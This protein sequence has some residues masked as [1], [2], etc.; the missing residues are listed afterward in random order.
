M[1]FEFMMLLPHQKLTT[2][3]L[4]NLADMEWGKTKPTSFKFKEVVFE[5]KSWRMVYVG[6]IKILVDYKVLISSNLPIPDYFGNSRYF[7]NKKP[8][9]RSKRN[10]TDPEK[11]NDMYFECHYN[12]YTKM[13]N[14]I[15]AIEMSKNISLNEFEVEFLS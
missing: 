14:L 7:A 10:F 1:Q 4:Q 6:I 9:H 5:V 8:I 3:N 11:I 12:T 2:C 13:R 15:K